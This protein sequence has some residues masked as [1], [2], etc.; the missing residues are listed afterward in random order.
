MNIAFLAS[1]RQQNIPFPIENGSPIITMASSLW[2]GRG[3][4]DI[5]LGLMPFGE[6]YSS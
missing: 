6:K 5:D 3:Q 4:R 1:E 2:H